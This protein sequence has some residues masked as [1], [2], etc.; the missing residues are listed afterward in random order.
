MTRIDRYIMFEFVR[1]FLICFI[2]FLGL[3]VVADFV[4]NIDELTKYGQTHGGLPRVLMTHYG[5][6]VPWFFDLIGRIV[7]L[8]AAV[9]SITSLQ[10][11]NEMAAM[12]AAGISRWRIA[13]PLVFCVALIAILGMLNR[14]LVIPR[15]G[16]SIMRAAKNYAGDQSEEVRSQYDHATEIFVD[17]K[18]VIPAERAIESPHFGLP[19]D[20]APRGT[21]IVAERAIHKDATAE[22]PRGFLVTG[23][24]SGELSVR[25]SLVKDGSPVVIHPHD[26][27]WLEPD[28]LYVA[29]ELPFEQLRASANWRQY[30]STLNLISGARN[31]SLDS[32]ADVSVRIHARI[33]QPVMDMIVLFLGLPI[34][35]SRESRNAFIAVGSCMSV[36]AVFVVATLGFHSMGNNYMIGPTLAV[37][38]PMMIFVP[39]ATLISEPLRR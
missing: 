3:F 26:A 1:V 37:W 4:N 39:V 23:V 28:Q 8:V 20:L 35:L 29:T 16:S 33:L 12:M 13:K 34:V 2:T 38:L 5:P 22:R 21:R 15:L 7:A 9:F 27:A 11:N 25:T 36:V 31:K 32:G 18:G 10:R 30:A 17:G 14:E 6:K 24:E 19:D